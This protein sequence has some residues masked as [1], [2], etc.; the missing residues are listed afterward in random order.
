ML[1]G[2]ARRTFYETA[3]HR[4]IVLVDQRGTGKSKP[5]FCPDP[6]V[7]TVSS[8]A[9]IRAYWTACLGAKGADPRLFT[10]AVAMD[11]LDDVRGALDYPKLDLYG[12]SYGATA[13]QYYLL[14]HGDRVRTAILDGG[15]LLDIPIFERYAAQS[16]AMLDRLFARCASEQ[17]VPSGLPLTCS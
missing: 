1:A 7:T 5:L 9:R 12:A 10:T 15:T 11:D 4:D 13:V 6:A 8:V 3:K 2:W 17:G 16:Q 14:L